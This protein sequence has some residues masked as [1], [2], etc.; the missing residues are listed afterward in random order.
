MRLKETNQNETKKEE[1]A[2]GTH[3]DTVAHT[4]H[5]CKYCKSTS[6]EIIYIWFGQS[7]MKQ[8]NLKKFLIW[9]CIGCLLIL[10][11][12]SLKSETPFEETIFHL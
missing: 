3:I 8:K 10:M 6:P 7:I 4:L 11:G 2:Q 9:F 5:T 12:L 1:K